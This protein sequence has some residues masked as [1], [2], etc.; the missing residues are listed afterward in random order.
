[1]T[2][3]WLGQVSFALEAGQMYRGRW[4]LPCTPGCDN[5]PPFPTGPCPLDNAELDVVRAAVLSSL[6]SAW[7][8]VVVLQDS[9]PRGPRSSVPQDWPA[10]RMGMSAA[11]NPNQMC[12]VFTEAV[13]T[14]NA[15][16]SSD[17]LLDMLR[18]MGGLLV[19][20]WNQTNGQRLVDDPNY[21]CGA[22]Q[23]WNPITKQCQA[24]VAPPVPIP[25]PTPVPPPAPVPTPVPVAQ[26][27]KTN[28]VA[29][30]GIGLLAILGIAL[31]RS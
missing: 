6:P 15:S 22:G 23:F 25:P 27:K 21:N 8:D 12:V 2:L 7:R 31:V 5:Q 17:V 29:I 1:M 4:L 14:Q 16:L 3:E 18:P 19:N 28:W 26:E 30:G 10:D 13:A 24:V 11:E 9:L 20:F